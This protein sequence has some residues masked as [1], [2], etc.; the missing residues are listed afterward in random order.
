MRK[1]V[2]TDGTFTCIT[3]RAAVRC[4]Q[5]RIFVVVCVMGDAIFARIGRQTGLCPDCL[6]SSVRYEETEDDG[7]DQTG[8]AQNSGHR[9]RRR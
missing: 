9:T 6:A 4:R 8:Y 2:K 5:C 7:S 1:L 3:G